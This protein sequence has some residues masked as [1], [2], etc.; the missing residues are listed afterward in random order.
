MPVAH[1]LIQARRDVQAAASDLSASELWARP[2]GAASVGFHLLHIAGSVDRLV[3]YARG[4]ALT[5]DQVAALQREKATGVPSLTALELLEAL[6]LAVEHAL[7]ALRTTPLAQL[8]DRREVGRARRPSNVLGLL[9]HAAEH[10]QRHT[11]QVVTTV[12]I[13]RGKG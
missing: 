13:L 11:G 12:K 6:D 9:F 7:Q 8:L 4:D 2:G 5:P 3:S 1:A 10:A